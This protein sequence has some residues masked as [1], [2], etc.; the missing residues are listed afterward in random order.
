MN[1]EHH[2]GMRCKGGHHRRGPTSYG[3]HD[4]NLVFKTL[5]LQTGSI[6]LDLG[7]G[8]GDYSVHAACDV[9][10][11]GRVYALDSNGSMLE[12]VKAQALDN[13]LRNIRTFLGDMTGRLPFE[14][15]SV[16]TCFMSTSLHCMS[17]DEYGE[18]IFSEIHRVLESGGQLA[19]LECKKE[20]T[21]FGPPLH[22]RISGEELKAVLGPLGFTESN[23]IDLGFNYLIC[24]TKDR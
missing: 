15:S 14:D 12:Q 22:M 5:G 1:K 19:V 7:C 9:G 23:Y 2:P 4:S 24:F 16:Q 10:P 8:P 20:K 21:D 3:M 11:S 17:L 6:F 13:G 18:A